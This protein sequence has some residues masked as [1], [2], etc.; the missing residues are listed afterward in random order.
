MIRFPEFV[1]VRVEDPS[2][3][4][5]TKLNSINDNGDLEDA[6][7]PALNQVCSVVELG[8]YT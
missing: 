5:T 8:K 2:L 1:I 7:T 3:K 4:D 6:N